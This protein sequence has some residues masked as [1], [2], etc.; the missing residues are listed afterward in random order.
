MEHLVA[1]ELTVVAQQH[2]IGVLHTAGLVQ[3]IQHP[4]DLLIYKIKRPD[5]L[6]AVDTKLMPLVVHIGEV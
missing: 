4:A 2:D 6:R 5:Q 3:R 1:V